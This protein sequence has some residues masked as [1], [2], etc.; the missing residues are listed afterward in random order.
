MS[1]RSHKLRG[2]SRTHGR[3]KKAGRGAGKRGGRGNAGL[4]KHRYI[5]VLKYD[6][7]RYGRKGFKRHSSLV[8]EDRIINLRTLQNIL[9]RLVAENVAKK[10]GDRYYV[11][12]TKGGFDKL[13][14]KG[15]VDRE[16]YIKVKKA[17]DGSIRKVKEGGGKVKIQSDK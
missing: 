16:L 17:T 4:H 11:D 3:G 14:S 15:E 5:E 8:K 6:R 1:K 9:P 7:D 10:K 13:L 12:L 2:R